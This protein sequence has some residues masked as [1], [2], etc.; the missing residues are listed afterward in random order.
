MHHLQMHKGQTYIIFMLLFVKNKS[1][2]NMA[3]DAK[4]KVTHGGAAAGSAGGHQACDSAAGT[5]TIL[6]LG[7]GDC[8]VLLPQVKPQLTL[9]SEV[10][11]T[12]FTM[13]RLLSSMNAHVAL[14]RLKVAEVSPTDLTRV[15][16]LSRVD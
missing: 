5:P 3:A 14:E 7:V 10:E 12:F 13:I 11:V 8:A 16:L 6:S 4:G 9:V 2:D 1:F 15:R